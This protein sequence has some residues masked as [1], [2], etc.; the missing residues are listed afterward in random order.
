M[1]ESHTVFII[2]IAISNVAYLSYLISRKS[3]LIPGQILLCYFAIGFFIKSNILMKQYGDAVFYSVIIYIFVY[4]ICHSLIVARFKI[5]I[6]GVGDDRTGDDNIG[7]SGLLFLFISIFLYLLA[8]IYDPVLMLK[9]RDGVS[10]ERGFTSLWYGESFGLIFALMGASYQG[11]YIRR[12]KL[13]VNLF[14]LFFILVICSFSSGRLPLYVYLGA[15]FYSGII[16]YM[17][18]KI[19]IRLSFIAAIFI[20]MLLH[21]FSVLARPLKGLN[22]LVFLEVFTASYWDSLDWVGTE[23]DIIENFFFV[24]AEGWRQIVDM[25]LISGLRILSAPL[26]S[27]FFPGF[28]PLDVTQSLWIYAVSRSE[29]E[30]SASSPVEYSYPGSLPST[31]YGEAYLNGGFEF[32]IGHLVITWIIYWALNKLLGFLDL[33]PYLIGVVSTGIAYIYRGSLYWCV[34]N[35]AMV[36]SLYAVLQIVFNLKKIFVPMKKKL[37]KRV[38]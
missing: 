29:L 12:F 35:V 14:T 20:P 11:Y 4:S 23:L 25:P 33:R 2:L 28:K 22:P 5:L 13:I 17:P 37:K 38:N 10:S 6:H 16:N 36:V 18:G 34:I 8:V 30:F 21:I 3:L 7:I 32:I 26:P 27:S 19:D 31:I 24:V 15:V 1:V 9:Y